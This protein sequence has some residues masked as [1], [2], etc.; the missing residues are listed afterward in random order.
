MSREAPTAG[1]GLMIL[2][3]HPRHVANILTGEKTVELRRTR[4]NVGPGQPI[5]IYSTNPESALVAVGR[6]SHVEVSKPACLRTET[7]LSAARVS[8]DEYDAYFA[9]AGRAVALHLRE[10]TPLRDHVA[11]SHIRQRRRYSPPQTWH[12]FDAAALGDLL[13]DHKARSELLAMM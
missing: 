13:G 2:S 10:V 7:L 1:S 12:F 4:P 8:G 3:I 9:G 5:A 11:L 6:V